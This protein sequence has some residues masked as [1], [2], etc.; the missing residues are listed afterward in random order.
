[1][2]TTSAADRDKVALD[3]LEGHREEVMGHIQ[4]REAAITK[5]TADLKRLI[6]ANT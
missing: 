3:I 4:E 6:E 1:M 2:R 5:E